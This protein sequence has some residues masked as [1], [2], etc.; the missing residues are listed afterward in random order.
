MKKPAEETALATVGVE[1]QNIIRTA[2]A[3]TRYPI[4]RL[5][6]NGEI[7]I[8]FKAT[9]E[10]GQINLQWEVSHN[11]KYGQPGPLAYRLDTLIVNRRIEQ[12]GY[13]LPLLLRLGGLREICRELDMD[14]DGGKNRVAIR[15]AL[16]QNASTMIVAQVGYSGRDK[17]K[18]FFEFGTTRYSIILGG[19]QLPDGS[20]ADAVYILLNPL[21]R[22]LLDKSQLRPLDYDYLKALKQPIA[23]R[24]YELLSFQI[25]GALEGRRERRAKYLYSE[26]CQQAPQ[27]RY[28]QFK[29]MH[30]QMKEVHAQHL[31]N[32]YILGPVE[33]QETTDPEGH[34]DWKM[35]YTPGPRARAHYRAVNGRL[36]AQ[37]SES[38]Q[39]QTKPQPT[40]RTLKGTKGT[41][42]SPSMIPD[43]LQAEPLEAQLGSEPEVGSGMSAEVTELIEC[44]VAADLNRADAERFACES[45]GV[46]R[47]QLEYLPFVSE[48]KSSR[49]AYLRRAIEGEFGPPASYA[50][51]QAQQEA[52]RARQEAARS[53]T[54]RRAQEQVKV[55]QE[56]ARQGHQTRFYG[57]YEGYLSESMEEAAQ[58]QPEASMALQRQEAAQRA[59]YTRG[60][61]AGRPL[62][63]KALDVFDQEASRLERAREFW[64]Q[65]GAEL[66]DF[67]QWDEAINPERLL[68]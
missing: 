51:Q 6:K 62:T 65:H 61:L 3:L 18:R 11:S 13:P 34:V 60:P 24:F 15:D 64:R 41:S 10:D 67:W 55:S 49:G 20:K 9:D 17:S 57:A 8:A 23:Q 19:Q 54:S 52:E 38:P 45:P 33:F 16:Y 40:S 25:Y 43:I 59:T 42:L 47:R 4:H 36:K 14:D 68:S 39:P 5:T 37:A 48:F 29:R 44:L 28:F 66:L 21:Y 58:A 22:E 35:F 53:A 32:G 26:F 30:M 31:A 46:C 50:R 7:T 63:E 27:Q 2:T 1:M 12:A 56:Q